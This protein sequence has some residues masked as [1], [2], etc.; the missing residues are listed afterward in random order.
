M[1]YQVKKSFQKHSR[2]NTQVAGKRVALVEA[3]E[4][5]TKGSPT[6]PP[7]KVSVPLATQ[8]E[9]KVLFD[10]G[11]PCI[12]FVEAQA[13]PKN[14]VAEHVIESPYQGI[15]DDVLA[16]IQEKKKTVKHERK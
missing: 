6:A 9:L 5:T 12:E 14:L 1:P 3:Y 4:Y 16:E 7:K 10:K 2:L 11:D 13:E 15:E 8:A